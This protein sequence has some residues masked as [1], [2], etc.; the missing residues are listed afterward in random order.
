ML[1]SKNVK[2]SNF[3]IKIFTQ[4]GTCVT[5]YKTIICEN[6]KVFYHMLQWTSIFTINDKCYL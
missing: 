2:M 6:E 5:K 4:K 3:R 1:D